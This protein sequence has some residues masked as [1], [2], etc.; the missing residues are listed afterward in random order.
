MMVI[1]TYSLGDEAPEWATSEALENYALTVG[2][3]SDA[4][5]KFQVVAAA[6]ANKLEINEYV[7][8]TSLLLQISLTY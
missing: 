8:C 2:Q 1:V 3:D 4:P 6:K 7:S 5:E